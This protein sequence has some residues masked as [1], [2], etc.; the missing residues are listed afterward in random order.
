MLSRGIEDVYV[1]AAEDMLL[2]SWMFG[3]V[4]RDCAR[5]GVDGFAAKLFT[6]M[7]PS[8]RRYTIF[9]VGVYW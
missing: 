4:G 5:G 9:W 6:N 8:F 1:V 7:C 2:M 3:D